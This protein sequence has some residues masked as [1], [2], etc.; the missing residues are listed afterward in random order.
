[1]AVYG[2]VD[3]ALADLDSLDQMQKDD[4]IGR[5]DAAVIDMGTGSRVS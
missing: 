5:F 4:L 3:D 2:N 1:V